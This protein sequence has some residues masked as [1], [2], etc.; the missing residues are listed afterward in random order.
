MD[1]FRLPLPYSSLSEIEKELSHEPFSYY[2]DSN[3][4]VWESIE[5]VSYKTIDDIKSIFIDRIYKDEFKIMELP[6]IFQNEESD[7][8][9]QKP[10]LFYFN[11]K[12]DMDMMIGIKKRKDHHIILISMDKK[13]KLKFYKYLFYIADILSVI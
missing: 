9:K 7:I 11:V 10:I 8:K 1:H 5:I 6:K 13:D 2:D 3:P 12:S 4:D